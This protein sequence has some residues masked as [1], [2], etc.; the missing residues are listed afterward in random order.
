MLK[1]FHSDAACVFS[2]SVSRLDVKLP[3]QKS[4]PPGQSEIQCEGQAMLTGRERQ[5]APPLRPRSP[6]IQNYRPQLT[7]VLSIL[8]RIS[9]IALSIGAAGLV[10]WLLMAATG[11]SD[12]PQCKARS[13]RGPAGSYCSRSLMLF[14]CTF[15]AESGTL[16]GMQATAL[17]YGRFTSPDGLSL[18]EV[19]FLQWRRGP[20]FC[21]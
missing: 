18:R 8:N 20:V 6:N 9:G 15:V 10:V 21:C 5:R 17:P 2:E 1:N 19:L 12:M 11:H 13:P 7:S 4:R 3:S 14:F 16:F